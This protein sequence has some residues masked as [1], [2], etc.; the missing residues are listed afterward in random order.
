MKRPGSG[1]IWRGEITSPKSPNLSVFRE[2]R[3]V[4]AQSNSRERIRSLDRPV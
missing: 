1:L 2:E 4:S 3:S